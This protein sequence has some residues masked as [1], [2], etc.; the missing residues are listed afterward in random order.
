M[1]HPLRN[2]SIKIIKIKKLEVKS[3]FVL[4][5]NSFICNTSLHIFVGQ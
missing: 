2:I 4:L 1:K 5:E 3:K